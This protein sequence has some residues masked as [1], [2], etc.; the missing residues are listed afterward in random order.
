[1]GGPPGREW[2]PRG[3]LA[4]L[5]AELLELSDAHIEVGG[6]ALQHIGDMCAGRLPVVAEGDDLADL[7]FSRVLRRGTIAALSR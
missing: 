1:V 3:Q 2:W 5:T 6:I 7:A 4:E